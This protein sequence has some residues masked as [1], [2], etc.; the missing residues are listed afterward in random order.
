M[1]KLQIKERRSVY[2]GYFSIYFDY[3][4]DADQ[5]HDGLRKE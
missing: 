4:S 1:M 2:Q 5:H 3:V